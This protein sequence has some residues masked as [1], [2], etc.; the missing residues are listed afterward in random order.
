MPTAK[1]VSV[2]IAKI[3]DIFIPSFLAEEDGIERLVSYDEYGDEVVIDEIAYRKGE[4][5][6]ISG[7]A[8]NQLV[9]MDAEALS[10][11]GYISLPESKNVFVRP[12]VVED[13]V[14]RVG[15]FEFGGQTYDLSN[16]RSNNFAVVDNDGEVI[17]FTSRTLPRLAEI[18]TNM[19]GDVGEKGNAF[20]K[21]IERY[22]SSQI[23]IDPMLMGELLLLKNALS[24]TEAAD[25]RLAEREDMRLDPESWNEAVASFEEQID[26]T[27]RLDFESIPVLGDHKEAM[28]RFMGERI[29]ND[30][31]NI[32]APITDTPLDDVRSLNMPNTGYGS[33][34]HGFIRSLEN[35]G[36][37]RPIPQASMQAVRKIYEPDNVQLFEIGKGSVLFVEDV[38]SVSLYFFPTEPKL[39]SKEDFDNINQR[40][41]Y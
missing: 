15:Q 40:Y 27:Y 24:T 13:A 12:G 33:P 29:W 17:S 23:F 9:A 34:I 35:S 6:G 28:K 22:Y 30:A 19:G 2:P 11:N 18:Y 4:Y 1:D 41:R 32:F 10:E 8:E 14:F 26:Q 3:D 7:N 37:E 31:K 39:I 20:M 21:E 16:F 25:A 38:Q 36:I 5:V